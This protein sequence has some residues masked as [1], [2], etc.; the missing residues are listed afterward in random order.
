MSKIRNQIKKLSPEELYVVGYS[1]QIIEQGV[2]LTGTI[3]EIKNGTYT[4]KW[5]DGKITKEDK[6]DMMVS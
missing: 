5:S 2:V 6:I 4:V 1:Y 3:T